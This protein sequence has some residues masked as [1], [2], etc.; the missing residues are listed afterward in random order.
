MTTPF[1]RFL[2]AH[3]DDRF[4]VVRPGGNHGDELIYRGTERLFQAYDVDY[5]V[6]DVYHRFESTDDGP[7][8]RQLYRGA[9]ALERIQ[10]RLGAGLVDRID[11]RDVDHALLD[12][13]GNVTDVWPRGQRV[14]AAL[15]A[16]RAAVPVTVA[17]QSWLFLG[18]DL[19]RLLAR[20]DRPV[21]LFCRERYSADH[22][23]RFDHSGD[24]TVTVSQ[25][26]ALY[27]DAADLEPLVRPDAPAGYTLVS[28][29]R[30]VEGV[31]PASD[32]AAIR[33]RA[34]R[35]VVADASAAASFEDFLT[36][37]ARAD[38]VYTDRLHVA[39]LSAILGV[40]VTLYENCYFKNRG[41]YE[42]SLAAF[43]CVSL[44]SPVERDVTSAGA[45][46]PSTDR[47]PAGSGTGRLDAGRRRSDRSGR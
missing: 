11:L 13:G 27:L 40:E 45:S 39:V 38:R 10:S 29:R 2:R 44:A 35:P 7:L 26:Q 3:A 42:D 8:R 20:A 32:R 14:L 1:E 34:D 23:R 24:V 21:R 22:L 6:V 33:A 17:P 30:D 28:F 37:V 46:V 25:D 19:D 16:N 12:G 31:V 41:V 18:T 47:D 15:C 4:A 43:D 36:L 5:R 9:R